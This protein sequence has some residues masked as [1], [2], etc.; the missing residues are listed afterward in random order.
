MQS[1]DEQLL[2]LHNYD[3]IT[4]PILPKNIDIYCF[5]MKKVS[6]GWKTVA[7]NWNRLGYISP[8]Q[9]KPDNVLSVHSTLSKIKQ[10]FIGEYY[11]RFPALYNVTSPPLIY[12][13]IIECETLEESE[14][15]RKILRESYIENSFEFM[16]KYSYVSD[17][18]FS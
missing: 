6:Y 3:C 7:A 5:E 13:V 12:Q 15:V 11:V 4:K 14:N 1:V 10:D 17:P 8:D 16:L 2:K 9:C 18:G